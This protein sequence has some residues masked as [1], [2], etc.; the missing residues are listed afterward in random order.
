MASDTTT[1]QATL[2]DLARTYLASLK[3]AV[4]QEA[5]VEVEKRGGEHGGRERQQVV[6][7]PGARH[8]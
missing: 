7:K 1:E 5:Q 2:Q 8:A 3:V 4:R 6:A